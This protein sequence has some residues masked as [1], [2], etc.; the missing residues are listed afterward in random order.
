MDRNLGAAQV[1]TSITD[2]NAF[3]DLY[4]WGR[5]ADGH[6][7]RTSGTTPTASPTDV[8]GN[9]GLFIKNNDRG[10]WR[11]TK[12]DNLWQGVA[13]INN[14]CPSG[15]RLPTVAEWVAERASWS[16]PQK[17]NDAFA[18]PLKLTW[19]GTRDTSGSVFDAGVNGRYWSST[20]S[21]D[22]ANLLYLYT[23][24]NPDLAGN[25]GT[26]AAGRVYGESV[27][28]LLD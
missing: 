22:N 6:Q 19:A 15:Y 14:P 11:T 27:R 26:G 2:V 4:Q 25:T 16:S 13:G 24:T 8:P 23:Y 21:G 5:G 10:D 3:G 20:V 12:N 7:S 1:A 17:S 28:C 18:S 9:G